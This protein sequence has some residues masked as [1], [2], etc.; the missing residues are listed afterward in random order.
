MHQN[1][2]NCYVRE[3]LSAHKCQIGLDARKFSSAKLSTFTVTP[4]YCLQSA[5]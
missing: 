3:N 4:E 5:S 1:E 2:L